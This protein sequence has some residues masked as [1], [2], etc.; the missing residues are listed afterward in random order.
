MPTLFGG[1]TFNGL[2]RAEGEL[3]CLARVIANIVASPRLTSDRGVLR[4]IVR[5]YVDLKD[6]I[7]GIYMTQRELDADKAL[8]GM[9]DV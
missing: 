4:L 6:R 7:A 2:D 3:A 8:A 5:D 9:N 1:V